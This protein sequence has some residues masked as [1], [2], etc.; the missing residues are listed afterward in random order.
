MHEMYNQRLEKRS[1]LGKMQWRDRRM[2]REDEKVEWEVW[3]R[4]VIFCQERSGRNERKS[5]WR[6]YI[7]IHK[8]RWIE[9]CRVLKT[10][11]L[12]VRELSRI[13][14]EVSIAKGSRWIE[15][16]SRIYQASRKFLNES[17]SYRECDK[18]QLKGLNR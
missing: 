16:L 4:K 14:R 18:K 6:V 9:R 1:Y 5:R 11:V 2:S 12:S 7:E 8:A 3:E 17:S 13:C 15:K 10:R